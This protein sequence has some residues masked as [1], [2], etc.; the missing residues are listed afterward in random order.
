M[1]DEYQ[2]AYNY[3]EKLIRQ[4][5]DP[6]FC[7]SRNEDQLSISSL[8][9]FLRFLMDQIDQ[10]NYESVWQEANFGQT[11]NVKAYTRFVWYGI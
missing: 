5:T 8:L 4:F 3:L 10:V 6:E 1:V 2:E 9:T 11:E 7:D